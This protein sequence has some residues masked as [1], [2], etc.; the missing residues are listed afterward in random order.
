MFED[1]KGA[2]RSRKSK[3]DRHYNGWANKKDKR[4]G[5]YLKLIVLFPSYQIN[6]HVLIV[7]SYN[8]TCIGQYEISSCFVF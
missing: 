8:G 1:S 7:Y 4:I 5:L 6:I 3:N 2:I